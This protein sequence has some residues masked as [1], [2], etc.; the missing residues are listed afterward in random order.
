MYESIVTGISLTDDVHSIDVV[1][2]GHLSTLPEIV[3]STLQL[4]LMPLSILN[5]SVTDDVTNIVADMS[6]SVPVSPLNRSSR[7]ISG[8]PN[9]PEGVFASYL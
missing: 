3:D 1:S 8:Y 9:T 2:A 6:R 5:E 4:T 7:D